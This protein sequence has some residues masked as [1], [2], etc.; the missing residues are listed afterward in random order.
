LIRGVKLTVTPKGMKATP[1]R[2]TPA[3]AVVTGTGN[4]P[5]A[6][7]KAGRPFRVTRFGS[8]S[9][10]AA[11]TLRRA[12][13]AHRVLPLLSRIAQFPLPPRPAPLPELPTEPGAV[14]PPIPAPAP[15][16]PPPAPAITPAVVVEKTRRPLSLVIEKSRPMLRAAERLTSATM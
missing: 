2:P 6:R 7:K 12:S 16:P 4:S 10:R 3:P 15:A 13:R 8:A 14:A 5:P 1:D 11:S 9:D